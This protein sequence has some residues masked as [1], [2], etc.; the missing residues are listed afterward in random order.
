MLNKNDKVAVK[1]RNGGEV[2]YRLSDSAGLR[3]FNR[4]ETQQVPFEEIEKLL[5]TPGGEY[6]IRNSLIIA[7]EALEE[8]GIKVYPEYF[9]TED[10]VKELLENGT[11]DQLED[12]LNF[13]P[14][15]VIDIIHQMSIK[16]ELPDTRKRK[17]IFEKT[18]FNID[19]ALAVNEA[20]KEETE[21][22]EDIEKPVRKAAPI[23]TV[24]R[25]SAPITANKYKVVSSG[26]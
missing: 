9:Y 14:K 11:L 1:S 2:F 6:L 13:A 4:G 15:G 17:M 16:I 18:G 8:L 5:Y 7:P 10:E 22:K 12:T 19:G 3:T 21:I 23:K 24:E 20:L 26:K 25:K